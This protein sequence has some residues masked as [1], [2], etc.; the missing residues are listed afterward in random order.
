MGT[1]TVDI[2]TKPI[3]LI[4]E[5]TSPKGQTISIVKFLFFLKNLDFLLSSLELHHIDFCDV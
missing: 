5:Y 1:P 4:F 2:G 3:F